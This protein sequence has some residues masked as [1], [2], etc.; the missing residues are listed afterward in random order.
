LGHSLWHS[1]AWGLRKWILGPH[2]LLSPDVEYRFSWEVTSGPN[3]E[4]WDIRYVCGDDCPP[5]DDEA[6][7][8]LVTA[9]V[10][11]SIPANTD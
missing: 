2:P 5:A 7:V 10:V 4:P 3:A 9:E 11:V 1:A 8:V 6:L